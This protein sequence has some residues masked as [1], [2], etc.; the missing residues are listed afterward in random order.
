MVTTSKRSLLWACLSACFATTAAAQPCT[1]PRGSYASVNGLEMYY[2]VQGTGKPL[3]LLHGG[4]TTIETSFDTLRPTLAKDYQTIAIEQQAHGR[5]ANIDRPLTYEQMADDTA[6]LLRQLDVRDAYVL[7]Y[8][9][10]G[11]VGLGLAIRH[12]ELVSKLIVAGAGFSNDGLIP[13][14]LEELEALD[15]SDPFL[16]PI[17]DAYTAVAPR[18]EDW[19]V[20]IA[21][22]KGLSRAFRGYT[23]AQLRTVETP[24]LVMNADADIFTPEHAA[25][26][27]R[28]LP[29]ASL[30]IL[31]MS[32]H[33]FFVARSSWILPM[34]Q[35]F[36]APAPA[37]PATP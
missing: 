22:I 18:P 12:P 9:D 33:F 27:K 15:P 14:N 16:A 8:S 25:E 7:G 4:L 29:N 23:P 30:A 5:T 35:E 37:D 13:G 34:L 17:R 11:I 3:V 2:Q 1:A 26:L 20:L 31:P 6:E 36:L 24:V 28:H 32:D 10:G 21:Q 19:P